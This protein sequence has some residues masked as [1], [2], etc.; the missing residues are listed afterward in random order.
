MNFDVGKGLEATESELP[1]L[2]QL[3]AMGYQYITQSELNKTRTDYR[4]VLLYD[5]L[6]QAIRRLNP[7]FD[8]DG[9]H[10]A[11]AQIGED[12][13]PHNLDPVETNE[14]I[15]AKL[16]GL[17]KSGGLE[18]VVVTQN[19]GEG[20]VQKVA[21]I[22]DLDNPQN[23]DFV[24]TN[25][26]QLE[27]LKN[28]IFPDVT[29]FVNG[30]PLVQ[31]ECKSPAI[32]DPIGEA[33]DRKNFYKYQQRGNGYEKLF[34]YNHCLIAACGTLARVGTLNSNLNYYSRWA[35][36]YPLSV[37]DVKQLCNGKAREQEIL[38]AGLLAKEN[39]LNHMQNFVLYDTI[40]HNRVKM[41]AKH[42]QYKAVSEC[43]NRLKL[44]E[45]IKDKGGI[46]WH[47]QGSGKSFSMLWFASQLMYK[48]GN[49]PIMIVTDRK[50]LDKQIHDTFKK[51]G[52]P[53]PIRAKNGKHLAELL[54]NPK[55]KTIMAIIDKFA[56]EHGAHTDEKVICLVD[57]A[58][59]SQYK[60]NAEQMRV[61]MPNAVFYGFT[62]TPIDK[63][64]K[65]TPRVFGPII[66][67]YGFRE[68][69][70]DG[71]TLPIRYHGRLSEL[72][73]EGG[74]TIDELFERI[75][76]SD[77]TVNEE[78]KD[79][80]KKQCATKGKIAEA[81]S[82]IKR[83]SLDLV[84]HYTTHIEPNGY[85]AMLV[86]PSREAAV[87]YK[88]NLDELNAP[89]SKI[90]MTSDL[91]EKGK[92]EQS[93][94]EYRLS[95]EQREQEAE[96]FKS[97]DNPTKI[98]I[99]VDMLLV[100]YDAPICQVL[101]LD[102]GIREHSLLQAIA[103]VNR[104]YD[105]PKTHGLIVDYSGVTKELQTALE[106]FEK[107]DIEGAL[108][109][110][111]EFLQ[112]LKDRHADAIVFFKGID[113][114]DND[115]IIEYF[116]PLDLRD[117]FEQA[118]KLFSRALDSV[119]PDKE[120]DPY[121]ED[122]KF[123]S[124]ARQIIRTYYEG[125]KPSTRPY[126]KKIQKLIDDHIRSLCI[127]E[128]INPMEITYE[129]FLAFVKKKVKSEKAQAALIKNKAIQVIEELRGNNPAYYEKLWERLQ[130]IIEEEEK[131]R[132]ENAQY[133][134]HQEVYAEVYDKALA[135]EK[136]RQK[137]FGD[138]E[139]TQFEFALYGEFN[140][141]KGSREESIE[142]TKKIHSQLVKETEIVGWRTKNSVE[143]NMKTILY[144]TLSVAGFED[145]KLSKLSEKILTLAKNRL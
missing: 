122:F 27:G 112:L 134:I 40:N 141:I 129:N 4:D 71:A 52:F 34:F 88:K 50:Q 140:E 125:V 36:P 83:I 10:D 136:E 127:S 1:A 68:S 106:M 55:G 72:F 18:P 94:D 57:E 130:K 95:S 82:R 100:G 145:E 110:L 104:P 124:K 126:A 29:I 63:N 59:R 121:I 120:A 144:D 44:D 78:L 81:P 17:S 73:V 7:D 111:N 66:D 25:Q 30:I 108:D 70:E 48:F 62:G 79:K 115:A 5:R 133:F 24:V 67:K 54:K 56:T 113:R 41:I 16:I 128:L 97:A 61:S 137:V 21:K 8:D 60:I 9:I 90:I 138:Y 2:E 143:K 31:I 135:E 6:E 116:E 103:R 11:V 85:K 117:E 20:P 47:T 14:K 102:K 107:D 58:H 38:I 12:R 105:E 23:N 28:P 15:R 101:Y 49:P 89:P 76:G 119:M 46:I 114:E 42:Q 19:F 35:K 3:V 118:F 45:D 64:D 139:A 131:R 93:W 65:S 98:L 33:V 51:C 37:D 91:G 43:V 99:V 32:P 69:Q 13:F 87:F 84:K 96:L 142:L 132:R 74:E 53:S 123:L 109:P 80:L 75:I 77:P 26:F 22:F 92:D 86:A 39:L